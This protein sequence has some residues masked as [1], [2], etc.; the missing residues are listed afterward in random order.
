MEH[1]TLLQLRAS[2]RT[3]TR[4]RLVPL[5]DRVA[6]EGRIPDEVIEEM[7][8]MGLF[9][10]TV[11]EQYGGLGLSVAE[12]VE[13]MMELT[14]ASAAFRSLLA[15]NLGVGSLGILLDGTEEQR[16]RWLPR[17]ANG[18]VIAAF[19]LTEP[20]S[21]SDSAAMRTSAARDGDH[22]V[23]NGSKRFISNAPLA[24]LFTILARTSVERLPKN[25]HVSAFLVPASTPGLRVG[26]TDKKMGH[27]G[28][29]TSDVYLDNV[30]I[31]S[32]NL[33]G[34]MEGRGFSTAMKALDRG[35]ISIAALCVGQG[36][37]ILHD[38]LQYALQRRQFGKPIADFQLVQAMLADSQADLYAAECM[39]KE[40]A[41]RSDAGER[42]AMQASCCKMFASEM[43]GRIADRAVQIHGGAGYMQESKV[44]RFY[45]DVRLFRIYEGT[46]QIQQLVIA[47][48]M[49]KFEQD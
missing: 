33:L 42:I 29:A 28:A 8:Q 44:E 40:T 11:P 14:W 10:I 27:S 36:R 22:Y 23:L 26:G 1:D 35:R 30:R 6:R 38:A 12:E 19:A 18:D 31:P 34:G 45:R 3:F 25:A 49:I 4:K 41:R 7:R 43:V 21:G 48:E 46:T 9:G 24:G 13:V 37:R 32:E 16:Q 20:D 15:M 47:R 2:I 5:E 39:L 17:L